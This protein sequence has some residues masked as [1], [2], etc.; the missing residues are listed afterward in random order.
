LTKLGI[1]VRPSSANFLLCH[2][3]P[4]AHAVAESLMATGLV[5][6]TFET[7]SRL[8]EM[9]RFTVRAPHENDR[10]VDSLWNYLP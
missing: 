2:V 3:G 1:H 5:V 10:L 4:S 8:S 6:R 9:L 7:S